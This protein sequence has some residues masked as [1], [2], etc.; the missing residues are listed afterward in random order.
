MEANT[1][2]YWDRKFITLYDNPIDA[3]EQTVED[4]EME[5]NEK[6]RNL[7]DK[8]FID[9]YIETLKDRETAPSYTTKVTFSC[10]L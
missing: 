6:K 3:E 9:T 8:E 4:D 7:E 10:L 1:W 5:T 2:P